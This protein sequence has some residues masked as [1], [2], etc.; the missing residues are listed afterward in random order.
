MKI[1]TLTLSPAYDVHAYTE[2][3]VLY[4]EHLAD[5]TSRDAGGKGVNI[6][7]AL[8]AVG[9]ENTALIALGS[10]N[11]AEF[12]AAL[13]GIDCVF[14]EVPGRIRENLTLHT[15]DGR[16]TRISFSGFSCD[17]SLLDFCAEQILADKDTIVTLT[18][19]VPDGI[20]MDAVS[21]FLLELK[22]AGVKLVI[23][24]RSFTFDDLCRIKPWLIKPNQEEISAY[25]ATSV[26]TPEQAAEAAR[27][28]AANGI[29]NVMISLG[30]DGAVLCS[31]NVVWYAVP[32]KLSAVSTVG[33]GDSA[34]AG[35]L[36][37]SDSAPEVRL[38]SAV[39]FGSAACLTEG[40]NPPRKND[41]EEISKQT[42]VKRLGF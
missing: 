31:G 2:E 15:A 9:V 3:L 35:F 36:A 18:G 19:R 17:T 23:D 40:S 37:A 25:T 14:F 21:G 30:G 39:S 38:K 7:R 32:P 20:S 16:E 28:L 10:E 42:N 11:G 4:R 26:T 24:S 41:I 8:N 5:V 22:A 33:A 13:D 29:E 1:Y 27:C 34:I 12:R 6:S